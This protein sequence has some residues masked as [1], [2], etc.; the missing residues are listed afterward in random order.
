[1]KSILVWHQGSSRNQYCVSGSREEPGLYR[2]T[3]Y[4]QEACVYQRYQWSKFEIQQGYG[5]HELEE[6][7]Q[8]H[9][10]ASKSLETS[11]RHEKSVWWTGPEIWKMRKWR[12]GH[13]QDKRDHGP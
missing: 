11:K 7:Y 4:N 10:K 9:F 5:T 12:E 3:N 13:T 1:V 6:F 2:P 8:E